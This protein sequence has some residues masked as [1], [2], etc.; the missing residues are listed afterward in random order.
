L[1][2]VLDG[3]AKVISGSKELSALASKPIGAASLKC[4][5]SYGAPPT[6]NLT[7]KKTLDDV[8]ATFQKCKINGWVSRI[9]GVV[10]GSVPINRLTSMG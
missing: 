4:K 7:L 3:V 2:I 5:R 10:L 8:R 6:G 1:R 9:S